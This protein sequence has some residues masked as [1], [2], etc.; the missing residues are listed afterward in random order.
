MPLP[1]PL[2]V[3]LCGRGRIDKK[4][5]YKIGREGGRERIDKRMY[6]RVDPPTVRRGGE[7]GGGDC[8][9]PHYHHHWQQS[10]Q[11][12]LVFCNALVTGKTGCC[13]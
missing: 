3:G 8:Y 9:L 4:M 7:G 10:F 12:R 11:L 6:Y 1:L 13:R 5:C 2:Q